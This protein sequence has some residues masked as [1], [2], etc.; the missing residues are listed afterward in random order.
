MTPVPAAPFRPL[1]AP[2]RRWLAWQL[3]SALLVPAALVGFVTALTGLLL[4]RHTPWPAAAALAGALGGILLTW[5]RL[6][7]QMT[8]VKFIHFLEKGRPDLQERLLTLY[9]TQDRVPPDHPFL[10]RLAAEVEAMLSPAPPLVEARRL[11]LSRLSRAL[12]LAAGALLLSL[13]PPGLDPGASGQTAPA[14]GVTLQS[15]RVIPPAHTKLLPYWEPPRPGRFAVP[16]GSRVAIAYRLHGPRAAIFRD[17][18]RLQVE[19]RP[20]DHKLIQTILER[21][22]LRFEG[23]RE[24]FELLFEPI[25]DKSPLLSLRSP[26]DAYQPGGVLILQVEGRDDYGLAAL[27]LDIAS[28]SRRQSRPIALAGEPFYTAELRLPLAAGH[29]GPLRI[30]ARLRDNDPSGPNLAKAVLLLS[31]AP[32]AAALPSPPPPWRGPSAAQAQPEPAKNA[33]ASFLRRLGVEVTPGSLGEIPAGFLAELEALLEELPIERISPSFFEQAEEITSLT[34]HLPEEVRRMMEEMQ[35][36]ALTLPPPDEAMLQSWQWEQGE[37]LDYLQDLE[38]AL[39]DIAHLQGTLDLVEEARALEALEAD[40]LQDVEEIAGRELSDFVKAGMLTPHLHEQ[41][42]AQA[43]LDRIEA[44]AEE[45]LAPEGLPERP[46]ADMRTELNQVRHALSRGDV[47]QAHESTS[48][49]HEQAG[50]LR[51]QVEAKSNAKLEQIRSEATRVLD[52]LIH[53]YL[54]AAYQQKGLLNEAAPLLGLPQSVLIGER[55]AQLKKLGFLQHQ[56]SRQVDKVNGRLQAFL[57]RALIP[58]DDLSSRAAQIAQASA[59]AQRLL[60]DPDVAGGEQQQR[61]VLEKANLQTL[62]LMSSRDRLR[63]MSPDMMGKSFQRNMERMAKQ[64]LAAMK[65]AAEMARQG[66]PIPLPFR[67]A[68]MMAYQRR[69]MEEFSRRMGELSRTWSE[70]GR[71]EAVKKMA[72]QIEA[73][74]DD[75]PFGQLRAMHEMSRHLLELKRAL[76]SQGQEKT[77]T[78]EPG[79]PFRPRTPPPLK[80]APAPARDF[81]PAQAPSGKEGDLWER[82][83]RRVRQ[84]GSF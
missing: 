46:A 58:D 68:Q 20:G 47:S 26:R 37:V 49:L 33:V 13:V 6:R 39:R 72:G 63:R 5:R 28:A 27:E 75:D 29:R 17:G 14:A 42:K 21:T 1:R 82:Y 55:G 73:K 16:E 84:A 35:E 12:P 64:Q 74:I 44:L 10:P 11:A 57:M 45:V 19:T 60:Q 70:K 79:R 56:L 15:L 4:G 30:T 23:E 76:L 71:S 9:E 66:L 24:S 50:A 80:G 36:L 22:A 3:L 53:G 69:L 43:K 83:L 8:F 65:Q 78:S 41:R 7:R 31:P 52:L 61:L 40:L 81:P 77:R 54:A 18:E 48:K 59:Q 34:P 2:Y 51:R 25:E 32:Q 67:A 62:D 38:Q